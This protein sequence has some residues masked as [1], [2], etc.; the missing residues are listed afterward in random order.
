[1]VAGGTII[2]PSAIRTLAITRSIIRNGMKM[3]KPIW[4]AVF[5]SLVTYAGNRIR[6]GTA[7]GP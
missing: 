3:V 6:I 7:S 5:S 2:I 1:M 4:N